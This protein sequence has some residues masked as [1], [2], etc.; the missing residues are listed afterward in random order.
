MCCFSMPTEVDGTNIFARML[1][2]GVQGLAYQM[3]FHTKDT[4]APDGGAMILPLPV[5]L[6]ARENSVRFL[7][8]HEYPTLFSDL[9]SG[10]PAPEEFTLSR[11]KSATES[12]APQPQLAVVEVGD[13]I[14]SFVPNQKD[15]ARLS[16]RFAIRPEVWR[17]IPA[18]VDYGFAVFQLKKNAGS[19]HPIAFEFDTR[20][21]T[22]LFFPTVHIHDG[23][24]H[25]RESF[26][27]TLYLQEPAF[28]AAV[29]GYLGGGKVDSRTQWERSK[30]HVAKF[31]SKH[32]SAKGLL[33]GS[34]LVHRLSLMGELPNVDTLVDANKILPRAAGCGRCA[35]TEAVNLSP[36]TVASAAAFLWMVKRRNQRRSRPNAV[37]LAIIG[38]FLG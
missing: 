25:E 10:F 32:V 3:S 24:V 12:A 19:T 14:A 8:L 31:A 20:M 26:S 37:H 9:R 13:F 29:S 7:D 6:P 34:A 4:S 1:R 22:Q 30:E 27:H 2:P 5:S 38:L 21:G 15:F 36:V 16:P 28:D 18:Y 33:D 23:E 11:S 17:K 35:T